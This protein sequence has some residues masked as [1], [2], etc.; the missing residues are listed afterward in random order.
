[1]SFTA[2]EQRRLDFVKVKVFLT[3][4][5]DGAR[6]SWVEIEQGAGVR[7]DS[8]GKSLTRTALRMMRRPYLPMPG[9]GIE[10][11]SAAIGPEIVEKGIRRIGHAISGAKKTTEN[12]VERHLDAMPQESKNKI[13]R[14]QAILST[15]TL[16]VSLTKALPAKG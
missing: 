16:S 2:N 5:K 12:I 6:V 10:M 15:V 1:M 8:R 9:H 3:E 13:L 7:M 11:S 4:Q 14:A